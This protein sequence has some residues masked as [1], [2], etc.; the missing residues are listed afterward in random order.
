[1][2]KETETKKTIEF[3]VIIFMIIG[4]SIR[5]SGL[6]TSLPVATPMNTRDRKKT[7][8]TTANFFFF[9]ILLY[10]MLSLFVCF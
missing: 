2:R 10:S 6:L 4:I 7:F 9:N 5:G 8:A 1:M 3:A